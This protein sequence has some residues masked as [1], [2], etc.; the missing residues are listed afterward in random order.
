MTGCSLMPETLLLRFAGPM[1]SW[2]SAA[3]SER[4][5][6]RVPTRNGVIGHLAA[7]LGFERGWQTNPDN[8]WLLDIDVWCRVDRPGRVEQ[9][10]Q[11]VGAPSVSVGEARKH[12]KI[13][14][15]APGSKADVGLEDQSDW[16]VP[17]GAGGR[18]VS[19]TQIGFRHYLADAEFLITVGHARVHELAEAT[20]APK[21]MTY[22]GRKAF[23]PTFPYHLGVHEVAGE[24]LLTSFPTLSDA[25]S[26]DVHHILG[27]RNPV[28]TRVTPETTDSYRNWKAA[29]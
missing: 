15:R 1:Q 3:T 26:L 9:D 29:A 25:V 16:Q 14:A 27:D 10:F 28:T 20:R 13:A 7:A 5:T 12:A 11:A 6:E 2:G 21:F 8:A 22:L 24:D 18:W 4:F 19:Q 17:N 23:A